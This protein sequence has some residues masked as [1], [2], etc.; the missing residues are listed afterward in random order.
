M[1]FNSGEYQDNPEQN[2][3]WNRGAYIVQAGAHCGECHTPRNIFGGLDH[4]RMF[5]GNSNGPD[6]ENPP[7]MIPQKWNVTDFFSFLKMG[8]TPDGDFAGGSMGHVISNTTSR[9]NRE[10][11]KAV[12]AYLTSFQ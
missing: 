10:D 12:I 7:P 6:K 9:L 8:M 2:Q 5:A 11:L 4:T 3:V 1:F